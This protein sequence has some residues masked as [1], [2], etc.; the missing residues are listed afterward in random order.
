MSGTVTIFEIIRPNNLHSALLVGF[1]TK[2]Y[3]SKKEDNNENQIHS[4]DLHHVDVGAVN[5]VCKRNEGNRLQS[6]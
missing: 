3:M 4:R 2:C 1:F 6:S 5:I